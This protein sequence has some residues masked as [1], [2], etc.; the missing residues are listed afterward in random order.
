MHRNDSALSPQQAEDL[1]AFLATLADAYGQRRPWSSPQWC[2]FGQSLRAGWP[3]GL[4]APDG[5]LCYII[6]S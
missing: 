2:R 3:G 1:V 4:D 6:R 5:D